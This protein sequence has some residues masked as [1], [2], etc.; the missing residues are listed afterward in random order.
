M[1]PASSRNG[2]EDVAWVF[3]C[4]AVPSTSTEPYEVNP[5][6]A[7]VRSA[8]LIGHMPVHFDTIAG[9]DQDAQSIQ[10]GVRNTRTI[11]I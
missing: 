5:R 6:Y 7:P 1:I 2:R 4:A 9:D 10:I 8:L 11:S 3:G